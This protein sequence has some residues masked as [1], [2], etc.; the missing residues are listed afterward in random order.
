MREY[1]IEKAIE[2]C[3]QA[4]KSLGIDGVSEEKVNQ[5]IDLIWDGCEDLG[6]L[7]IDAPNA[8]DERMERE[9]ILQYVGEK[10][11]PE[12][13]APD[14]LVAIYDAEIKYEESLIEI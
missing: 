2:S 6:L 4:L 10:L 9:R 5:V 3:L 11:Q 8:D 7:D 13:I 12:T 1:D 14:I